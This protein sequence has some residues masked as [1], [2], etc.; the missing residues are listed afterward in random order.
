MPNTGDDHSFLQWVV[1]GV[2][3]LGAAVS[4]FLNGKIDRKVSKEVHEKVA[5]EVSNKVDKE[6]YE[7]FK[8]GNDLQHG[9]THS[10][11]K[12]TN[13]KLDLIFDKLDGKQDKK[14]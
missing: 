14:I 11:Q 5:D 8:K 6:V 2:V 1:G 7:E 10:S 3:A 9:I 12:D 4:K 13:R